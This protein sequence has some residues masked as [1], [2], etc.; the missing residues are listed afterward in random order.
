[1]HVTKSQQ[2]L[3][4][5]EHS[6]IVTESTILPQPI[7]KLPTGTILEYHI[8]KAIVLERSLE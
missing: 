3:T 6:D 8:D 2:N 7:K 4:D 5:I 1:M